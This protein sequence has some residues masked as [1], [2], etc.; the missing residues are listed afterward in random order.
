MDSLEGNKVAAAVLMAGMA[1]VGSGL[2]G[3]YLVR[4]E[5]LHQTAIKI[6]LPNPAGKESAPAPEE[7]IAALLASADVGRGESAVKGL[8]CVACHSFNEGGKAGVGPNLYGVV[9]AKHAHMEGYTYSAALAAKAGEPWTYDELNKWLLKPSAYAPGTKM[10]YAGIADPKKRADVIDYL[11]SLSH[12]PLPLPNPPATDAKPSAGAAN[13]ATAMNG[14]PMPGTPAPAATSI[15]ERLA[16]ADPGRGKADTAKLGCVA[17]HSYNEGGK[18]GIGLNMWNVVGSTI[19]A[20]MENYS[21]SAALKAKGGQWSY[22]N[23]DAWLTKPA[24]FAPGTK[25]T[26]A[27]VSDPATRADLISYLRTLANDPVPLPAG[28]TPQADGKAPEAATTM[29]GTVT[30]GPASK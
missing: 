2:I 17:C 9:G 22:D 12:E 19:G 26:F 30:P 10:A 27:G 25:M 23:L 6:D 1:F 21:Y 29:P 5:P 11:H 7:P 3:G 15:E 18:A 20:H 13:T 16:S 14:A 24:S 4:P 8:G 28:A